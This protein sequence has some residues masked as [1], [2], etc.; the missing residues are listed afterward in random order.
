LS[1][2]GWFETRQSKPDEDIGIFYTVRA[3]DNSFR[4][5]VYRN[6]NYTVKVGRDG[7]NGPQYAKLTPKPESDSAKIEV[8]L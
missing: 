1:L 3:T 8:R 4:P 2:A 6:G 7:P 5:R